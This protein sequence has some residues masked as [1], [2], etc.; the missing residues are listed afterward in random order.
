MRQKREPGPIGH[1]I[2]VIRTAKGI[3]RRELAER[4]GVSYPYLSEIEA[5]KKTPSSQRVED[6]AAAIGV[7]VHE[8]WRYAEEL[9]AGAEVMADEAL[10]V[11]GRYFHAPPA[12]PMVAPAS[13][14]PQADAGPDVVD[15]VT[16]I[17]RRLPEEDARLLLD[18]ARRLEKS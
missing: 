12:S 6:I 13:A 17:A 7:P 2:R 3:N 18:F 15:E 14:P 10:P 4:S 9:Q 1:A 8:L 5:G 11:R 16:L